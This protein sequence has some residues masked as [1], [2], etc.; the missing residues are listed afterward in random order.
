MKSHS[1]AFLQVCRMS[2][3][4]TESLRTKTLLNVDVSQ[5]YKSSEMETFIPLQ[6]KD[7]N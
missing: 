2:K 7:L 1:T 6:N 4:E 5:C 3:H